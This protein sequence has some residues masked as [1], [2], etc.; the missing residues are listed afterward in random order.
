MKR[1]T[2]QA[3]ATPEFQNVVDLLAVLTEASNRLADIEAAA[4]EEF[5]SIID[6]YRKDYASA[7]EAATRAETA[8][9]AACRLHPEWFTSA[10]SIKTPWGKVSFRKTTSIKVDN[11]EAT[12]RLLRALLEPD[13]AE[14]YIVRTEKP[15]LE[16]MEKLTD[17]VLAQV[18]ARRVHG[19]SFSATPQKV[20]FGKAVK[21]AA[22]KNDQA[23]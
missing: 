18:M 14:D 21:E 7:Q 6:E 2:E 11:E 13:E 10:R 9:E 5:Q 17:D 16:A 22:E 4:N 19:D 3:P 12:C 20:D 1:T 23:A 8:L 15:N